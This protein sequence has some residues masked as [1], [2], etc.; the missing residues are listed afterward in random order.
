MPASVNT[1][2]TVCIVLALTRRHAIPYELFDFN[3][4]NNLERD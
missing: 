3:D 2:S 4:N 1:S